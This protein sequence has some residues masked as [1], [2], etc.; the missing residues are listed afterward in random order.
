MKRT[1]AEKERRAQRLAAGGLAVFLVLSVLAFLL[2][3]VC[4][5][6]TSAGGEVV[7]SCR[8]LE[9]SDPPMVA[10]GVVMVALLGFLFSEVSGFGI[11]LKSRVREAQHAAG[12][13]TD[14]ALEA[15][16]AAASADLLVEYSTS[17]EEAAPRT[18][19]GGD[20]SE[21][22][23][24]LIARYNDIRATM[25][26][27]SGRTSAQTEIYRRMT[28]VVGIDPPPNP[29]RMIAASDGGSRLAGVAA[30]YSHPDAEQVDVLIGLAERESL[31]FIQYWALRAIRKIAESDPGAFLP[32]SR[33]RLERL[34][35]LYGAGSDRA[36]EARSVLRR[37]GSE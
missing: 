11:S 18:I 5:G 33:V 15:R 6:T 34:I 10:G 28:R 37:I 25:P 14:A 16:G 8:H 20:G 4:D 35:G 2:W 1:E 26:G 22:L 23:D 24:H 7:Q 17:G 21:D 30:L 19:D 27:G 3:D 29:E 13:A 32:G 31:P 12:A 9:I 36:Y